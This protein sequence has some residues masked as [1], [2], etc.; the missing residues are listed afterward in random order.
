M[1][2]KRGES[3]KVPRSA[4]NGEIPPPALEQ[5]R[6]ERWARIKAAAPTWLTFAAWVAGWQLITAAMAAWISPWVWALSNGLMLLCGGG[7]RPL[8]IV[9]AL[10]L[11]ELGERARLMEMGL[12]AQG[13]NE[14]GTKRRGQRR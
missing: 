10:G 1:R 5:P 8:G 9:S 11:R 13:E 2:S 6:P 3:V 12:R 14:A 4:F 7:L